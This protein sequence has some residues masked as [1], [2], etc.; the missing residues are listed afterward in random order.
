M[1][2]TF[3]L[4]RTH[5]HNQEA[6]LRRLIMGNTYDNYIQIVIIYAVNA[7]DSMAV[8][9]TYRRIFTTHSDNINLYKY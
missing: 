8:P 6:M 5:H 3:E 4:I 1:E 2:H 7:L 9:L